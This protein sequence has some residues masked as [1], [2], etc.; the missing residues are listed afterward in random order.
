MDAGL[1][2]VDDVEDWSSQI[3]GLP[4]FDEL[5]DLSEHNIGTRMIGAQVRRVRRCVGPARGRIAALFYRHRSIGGYDDITDFLIAPANGSAGSQPGDS[6]T[7]WHLVVEG[8]DAR[9][10][11]GSCA[12]SRCN[13]AARRSRPARRWATSTS[14]S[15]PA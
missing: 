12:R 1:I 15:R 7:V 9:R 8:I 6:G 13:G 2:A 4:P 3:Y 5:A 11:A 10:H 14:P